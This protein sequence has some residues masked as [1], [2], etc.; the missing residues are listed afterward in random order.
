MRI[1]DWSSDVC[2]SDLHTHKEK[3]A[4]ESTGH[5][6]TFSGFSAA[7]DLPDLGAA[8]VAPRPVQT[9]LLIPRIA[10]VAIGRGL[11]APPPPP[12]GPPA[13]LC[14][15]YR[16]HSE[17]NRLGC[18]VHGYHSSSDE[19]RGGKQRVSTGRSCRS[20]QQSKK[21]RKN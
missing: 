16:S 10:E 20:T 12:T 1:S 4:Q 6:C 9:A 14:S 2:S 21:K 5:P 18:L 17:P 13:K 15:C 8:V 19:R 11:A 3:P 7:L